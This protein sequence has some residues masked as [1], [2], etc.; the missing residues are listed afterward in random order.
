M[1]FEKGTWEL[2]TQNVRL[3]FKNHEHAPKVILDILGFS[4]DRYIPYPG[5]YLRVP[6]SCGIKHAW[7][8]AGSQ[9]FTIVDLT[10]GHTAIGEPIEMQAKECLGC[11]EILT[12]EL[13]EP[14]EEPNEK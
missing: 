14:D 3:K 6:C 13:E 11:G 10:I 7:K 4:A 5:V 8:A 9:S 2:I 1:K 12:M